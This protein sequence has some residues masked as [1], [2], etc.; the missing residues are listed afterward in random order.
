MDWR[1]S[2]HSM[3]SNTL[4]KLIFFVPESHKEVV[5]QAVFDAGAGRMDDY[6]R[7][8]WETAGYGHFRPLS[9]SQPYIGEQ[10]KIE[11]VKEFRVETVCAV[12]HIRSVL[13]AMIAAHPYEVPAYDVIAIH[14]L[15]DF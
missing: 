4:V 2:G 6:D 5:K 11:Q 13:E 14:T 12:T 10:G 15:A 3:M 9:G 7:C 8:S 1:K